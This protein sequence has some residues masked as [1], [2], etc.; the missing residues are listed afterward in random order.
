MVSDLADLNA[1][2]DEARPAERDFRRRYEGFDTEQ[3]R[4]SRLLELYR[5]RERLAVERSQLDVSIPRRKPGEKA[6]AGLDGPTAH[7]Y[8]QSV[9]GVLEAWGFPG[10]PTVSF[11]HEAQDIR[12]NGKERSADGKGVRALLQAAMKV[13]LLVYCQEQ[14]RIHPGFVVLDT[15]LLTYREPLRSKHGE[16]SADEQALKDSG[17][18]GRFYGHL[19]ALSEI[20]QFLIVENSDPPAEA[21]ALANVQLFTGEPDDGRYGLFPRRRAG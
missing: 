16:L 13:A 12:L 2:L 5:R 19:A 10:K 21:L 11:D 7:T 17:V 14:R 9:Q 1:S 8:A 6:A 4:V 15:P 20:G 18:A 3:A